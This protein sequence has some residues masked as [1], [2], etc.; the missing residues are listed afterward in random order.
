MADAFYPFVENGNEQGQP[1]DALQ[2]RYPARIAVF[3]DAAAAPRVVVVEPKD[4]RSYLEEI[5]ATVTRLAQEQGGKIPFTVIREVVE[6]LIHAYFIEPTISILDGGNT[7]RF[8]DQGP[9]IQDK[10]RALE[11]GTTS[12]TIEMKRYIRGVGSGLPYAQQFLE[13]KG[14][15]LT[16]EDNIHKGTVITVSLMPAEEPQE[17]T[18]MDPYPA[19]PSY[20]AQMAPNWQNQGGMGMPQQP[21]QGWQPNA[22]QQMYPY[23][24]PSYP[25]QGYPQPGY[26]QPW[27]AQ[28]PAFPGAYPAQQPYQGAPTPQ[29]PHI[30]ERG[31]IALQY[32]MT[33]ESVGPRD[34]I[35]IQP[36][37][38]STWS[39]ELSQ[40]EAQGLLS[41][42]GGQK[43]RLTELGRRVL[44]I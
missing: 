35:A 20:P 5:T 3:D 16:V 27:P 34:L 11:Y 15:S 39:R 8:S 9:G 19:Y 44:G 2:V 17:P 38:E 43:R 42:Q 36:L 32:L 24:Q 22:G 10:A 25:Q 40:L 26:A 6:N 18:M 21:A 4:I 30:S 12:A 31:M 29:S 13:D 37:S 33:H 1:E 28:A 7:I 41:K 14:G 23:P